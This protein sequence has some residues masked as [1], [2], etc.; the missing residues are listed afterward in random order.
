VSFRARLVVAFV[1][2]TLVTLGGTFTAIYL[3]V[4]GS[5]L[6]QLDAALLAEAR[7]E[8]SEIQSVGEA[9]L[10]IGDGPGPI[11]DDIG[12][13]T[14]Y[15]ALY[16]KDGDVLDA[17]KTFGNEPPDFDSF[18]TPNY[19]PFDLEREERLRGVLVPVPGSSQTLLLAAPRVHLEQDSR[20][21]W[22]TLLVLLLAGGLVAFALATWVIRRLTDEHRRIAEVVRRVADGDLS[23]RVAMTGASGET[24]QLAADVDEMIGRLGLLLDAQKRFIAHA[25]HEMRSPLSILYGELS[26]ALRRPRTEDEYRAALIEAHDSARHLTAL[27]DDLLAVARLGSGEPRAIERV[28]VRD[29]VA[30]AIELSRRAHAERDVKV[31]ARG[32]DA[33]VEGRAAD[34]ER[35][36]AN[37]VINAIHHSP[38]GGTVDVCIER[39][40]RDV[41]IHVTDDGNGIEVGEHE[42]IFEPFYRGTGD[43]AASE[44]GTG[45][46]LAIARET[47]RSMGGDVVVA[48]NAAH[49]RGACFTV[50][51]PLAR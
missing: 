14:K 11:V 8:A 23:Q 49:A 39:S 41:S 38:E 2:I 9:R 35:M 29:A 16:E 46:G 27:I 44:S 40:P 31:V 12:P 1:S 20:Y 21:L 34:V 37:L 28:P 36:I 25:S 32:D 50:R 43:R 13:L 42:K 3:A 5:E 33:V 4:K 24:A 22:R 19:A 10:V 7:E 47:A 6:S 48:K 51:L 45:L 30:R 18:T 15:A 26:H 17:T